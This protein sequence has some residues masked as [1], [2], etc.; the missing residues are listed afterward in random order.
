MKHLSYK[1]AL[2]FFKVK[3]TRNK[4]KRKKRKKKEEDRMD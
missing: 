4:K 1:R 3:Y 2:H